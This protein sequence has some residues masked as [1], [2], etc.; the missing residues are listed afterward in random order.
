MTKEEVIKQFELLGYEL[1]RHERR[2]LIFKKYGSILDVYNYTN[3]SYS[4]HW[5]SVSVSI[6]LQEHQ[7][8]TELFKCYKWIE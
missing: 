3:V 8:L 4:K 1:I 2:N 6:T 7:L 5:N